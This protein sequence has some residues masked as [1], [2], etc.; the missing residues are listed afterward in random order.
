MR[1]RAIRVLKIGLMAL[2]GGLLLALLL[3]VAGNAWV[4]QQT[5]QQIEPELS[6]CLAAPV[7]IVFGTSRWTRSGHPNPHFAARMNAAARMVRLERVEHLLISGDNR[8]RFYNEPQA[9]WQALNARQV[10]AEAM[11]MDF[12]GFSTYDTLA[13][14]RDVFGVE[15]AVLITQDWHLPRALLIADALGLEAWG[16]VAPTR[17]VDGLWR[18]RLREWLARLGTLGD[19]YVWGRDPHFLGPLE[20]LPVTPQGEA[21]I[22]EVESTEEESPSSSLPGSLVPVTPQ[23]EASI[24]EVESTEEE[25]PS[26]SLPGPLEPVTP[27]GQGE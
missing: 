11:T 4:L 16:C 17:P 20:P 13:R 23:G 7:G 14:A 21:S 5:R 9:M 6:R 8:T 3:L 2:G 18:L 15:R 10:P 12:A 24:E 22:E 25:S 27:Q 19:L 1:R 26:S